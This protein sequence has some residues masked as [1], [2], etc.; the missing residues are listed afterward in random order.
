MNALDH[1]YHSWRHG[2][3]HEEVREG[4]ID[5]EQVARSAETL[6]GAE[7]I[8]HHA[9]A[10]DRYAAEDADDEAENHVPQRIQRW[11]LI[12][13][14]VDQV[15][16]FRWYFVNYRLITKSASLRCPCVSCMAW[17]GCKRHDELRVSMPIII[18]M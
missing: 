9:I 16:H 2:R 18:L 1:T 17:S 8:Y 7:Y 5:N 13:V 12:P 11:E 14:N 15:E 10:D 3:H 4:E 6:S